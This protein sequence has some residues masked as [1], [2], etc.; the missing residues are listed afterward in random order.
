M[1][2]AEY[3]KVDIQSEY[4]LDIRLQKIV[5]SKKMRNKTRTKREICIFPLYIASKFIPYKEDLVM[6][7]FE[8]ILAQA[9]CLSLTSILSR[10]MAF[11]MLT[12]ASVA[13]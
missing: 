13:T 10:F 2:Y 8:L 4:Q 1:K 6:C 5:T 7:S 3:L 12:R 11:S 9:S